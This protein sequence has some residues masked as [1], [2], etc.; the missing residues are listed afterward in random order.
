MFN[1][2]DILFPKTCF[3]CGDWGEYLCTDC[4]NKIKEKRE[5]ICPVCC[6]PAI[7][8]ITHPVCR[9]KY[10]LDGLTT[11]FSYTGLVKRIIKKL[12]F[13]FVFDV[14]K[15][16]SELL[17]TSLGE[18]QQFTRICRQ[19]PGLVPVPLHSSRERWRGFNQ[20]ELLGKEIAQ[21]LGINFNPKL[22][23]RIKNTNV[24][25]LL[26]KAERQKN[27]KEAFIVN[28]KCLIHNPRFILFDDVWTSGS[29]LREAGKVL[30]KGGAK[31]V[32]GLTLAS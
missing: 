29:T 14:N 15:L 26:S 22:L 11:V 16:L 19:S 20:A 6:R 4:L 23:I 24:Q 5:R 10:T 27:I 31:F 32:W 2:L 9:R 3:S 18:D 21:S 7:Y 8:G 12:K 30:K 13:N 17:I 25:S 1:L 28:P